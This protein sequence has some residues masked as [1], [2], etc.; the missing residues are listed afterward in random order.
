MTDA[1]DARS[2]PCTDTP[3]LGTCRAGLS[4][5]RRR[6]NLDGS[7]VRAGRFLRFTPLPRDAVA[8]SADSRLRRRS[9]SGTR[10]EEVC[11]RIVLGIALSAIC[12]AALFALEANAQEDTA[13]S[14]PAAEER[15]ATADE[16]SGGEAAS[17]EK[18][19][20]TANG[21]KAGDKSVIAK[22]LIND[23]TER[24][25]HAYTLRVGDQVDI[26]VF[27]FDSL[28]QT[29]VVV[30]ANGDISFMPVGKV[31]L[32]GKTVFEVEETIAQRLKD[33][34]FVIEP[35]VGCIVTGYAPRN[36]AI[37]GAVSKMAPLPVHKNIRLLELL[38]EAGAIQQGT[39]DYARVEVRRTSPDGKMHP[40][41]VNVDQILQSGRND[42]NIVIFEGDLIYIPRLQAA[43]PQSA[44]WV[45]VLGQVN[46]PGR[47]PIIQGRTP[48]TF[49]KLIA[50]VGDFKQFAAT[51]DVI[52]I[53]QTESGRSRIKLDFDEIID[54]N[55]PDFILQADDLIYVPERFF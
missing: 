13:G 17:D 11:M 44:E 34:E 27:K 10:P 1:A 43:T 54:G 49:T 5:N 47:H 32:L 29:N 40:I 14:K 12:G 6:T 48:F 36:V 4:S 41:P 52:V 55:E 37:I 25:L 45:Y 39:A 30:P 20:E 35:H 21:E 46:S 50:I 2:A 18:R 23:P 26:V 28:K 33:G 8:Q 16:S 7:A 24:D 42:Q 38:A 19:P 53:R 15:S 22:T 51:D 3:R 31:N 9:V